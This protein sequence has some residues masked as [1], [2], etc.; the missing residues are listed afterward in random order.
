MGVVAKEV[1]LMPAIEAD[2]SAIHTTLPW[3][4]YPIRA[5]TGV[6]DAI[7]ICIKLIPVG[8]FR[9]GIAG[10]PPAILIS[11]LEVI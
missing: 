2:P 5:V 3:S 11:V 1:I 6:A 4:F 9:A 10:I 8:D 7:A